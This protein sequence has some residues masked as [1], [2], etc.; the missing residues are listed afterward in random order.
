V[1]FNHGPKHDAL[2]IKHFGKLKRVVDR[3]KFKN[4]NKKRKDLATIVAPKGIL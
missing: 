3:R 1:Q 4:E 2:T